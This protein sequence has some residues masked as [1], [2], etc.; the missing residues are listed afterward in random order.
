MKF[1]S[2]T[3]F[4]FFVFLTTFSQDLIYLKNGQKVE[5]KIIEITSESVKYKAL[6]YLEGP[7]RNIQLYDVYMIK[8][9]NGNEEFF[10]LEDQTNKSKERFFSNKKNI[11]YI[12]IATG[13]GQSYGG[14]G[15][16]LQGR[17]GGI[18]GFGYHAGV[19]Y[20]P[21]I[22]E[23]KEAIWFSGGCKFFWYKAW[24]LDFQFGSVGQY[25]VYDRGYKY[26]TAYGPSV[27]L[28]GDWFFN[29]YVGMNGA[30]GAAFNVTQKN[31]ETVFPTLDIGFMVKF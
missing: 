18:L 26:G 23:T 8:Y 27:L 7:I 19:G 29:K 5:G 24:Y 31:V 10:N 15:V 12:S 6:D 11:Y 1:I 13:F 9:E 25:K 3:V 16:R 28:G 4:L 21:E 17:I 2:T 30:I 20:F 22:N 14:I